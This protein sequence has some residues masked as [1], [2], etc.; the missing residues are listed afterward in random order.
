[1]IKP[2]PTPKN[3]TPEPRTEKQQ[4]N[5][6]AAAWADKAA[7]ALINSFAFRDTAEGQDFWFG[8]YDRLSQIARDRVINEKVIS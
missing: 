8:V 4:T 5:E 1:M 7:H 2:I 6:K 3:A